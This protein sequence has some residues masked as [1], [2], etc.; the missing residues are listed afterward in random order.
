[1]GHGLDR[2]FDPPQ[3]VEITATLERCGHRFL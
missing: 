1:M 3:L 2:W